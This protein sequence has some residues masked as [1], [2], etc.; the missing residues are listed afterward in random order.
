ME[1]WKD[2]KK[3][4]EQRGSEPELWSQ[5]AW[6]LAPPLPMWVTFEQFLGIP[7]SQCLHLKL[8]EPSQAY[9]TKMAAHDNRPW[10]GEV[11]A[12]FPSFLISFAEYVCKCSYCY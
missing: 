12:D 8:G 4:S 7:G 11:S 9:A 1:S 3:P 6:I 5:A 10:T 2:R